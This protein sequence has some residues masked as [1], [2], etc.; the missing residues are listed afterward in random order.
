MK[1]IVGIP[2]VTGNV[3]EVPEPLTSILV[4]NPGHDHFSSKKHKKRCQR[5][6]EI[7]LLRSRRSLP[8]KQRQ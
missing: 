6:Q 8:A 2:G 4:A 7:Y 3:P 1:T 5:R